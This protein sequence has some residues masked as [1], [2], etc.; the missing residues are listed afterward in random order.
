M[1]VE[2]GA[3]LQPSAQVAPGQNRKTYREKSTEPE[4]RKTRV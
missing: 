3:K 1:E 4:R 2:R